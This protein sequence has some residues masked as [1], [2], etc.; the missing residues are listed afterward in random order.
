MMLHP[1]LS[2][3]NLLGLLTLWSTLLFALPTFADDVASSIASLPSITDVAAPPVKGDWLITPVQRRSGVYRGRHAQEIL[4][5][6]GLISRT[7]R[8]A[9]NAATIGFDNIVTSESLVRGVKPEARL[10]IDGKYYDVG[11][12]IG[13]PDYAYLRTEWL[14]TMKSN[15]GAFQL[16]GLEVGMIKE[17]IT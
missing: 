17:R 10:K 1:K 9:P 13:Q 8:L 3:H 6:N 2:F 4:M 5:T 7:W 16:A 11:G 15:P 12:L 14:N